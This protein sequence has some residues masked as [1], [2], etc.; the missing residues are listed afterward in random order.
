MDSDA[1]FA[2]IVARVRQGHPCDRDMDQPRNLPA[3]ATPAAVT[4]AEELI[5]YPLPPLLKR[6]YLEVANGGVGPDT[7]INGLRDGYAAEGIDMLES[8]R[9]SASTDLDP[10]DPP[11]LPLGVLFL[12]DWGCANS[13]LLD[14]REPDGRMWKW[15]EGDRCPQSLTLTEWFSLW[16]DGRL[17]MPATM[18]ELDLP[19]SEAWRRP[20]ED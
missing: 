8:Y 20:D 14:C 17:D 2:A 1:V 9:L 3:R 5:G 7:G 6:I 11:P 13:S 15:V 19:S 16:L 10:D 4:E 12:C 18:P